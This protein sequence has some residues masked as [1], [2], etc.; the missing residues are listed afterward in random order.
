MRGSAWLAARLQ[1]R[2]HQ[3]QRQP[4]GVHRLVGLFADRADAGGAAALAGAAA[5]QF[6]HGAQQV[7]AQFEQPLA[8]TDI[9]RNTSLRNSRLYFLTQYWIVIP[10]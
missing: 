4:L 1:T 3:R 8:E 2:L 6:L 10:Y 7:V 5:H 9:D